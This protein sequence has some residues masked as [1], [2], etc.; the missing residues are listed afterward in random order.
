MCSDIMQDAAGYLPVY[1]SGILYG[2]S[3]RPV[4]GEA[5]PAIVADPDGRVDGIVYQDLAQSAWKRL[6]LFEGESYIRKNLTIHLKDSSSISA[7]AYVI[8]PQYHHCLEPEP[9]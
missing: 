4:K 8:K 3:R 6:D 9:K 7:A 2:Y 1:E 5:D